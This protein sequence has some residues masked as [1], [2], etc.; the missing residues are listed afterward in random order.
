[1]NFVASV[2]VAA[3]AV[4]LF[5]ALFALLRDRKR[6]LNQIFFLLGC[7]FAVWALGVFALA[8]P[9]RR[10]DAD[11]WARVV[12]LDGALIPA[13]FLHLAVLLFGPA[14]PRL[15]RTSY[16]TA[17]LLVTVALAGGLDGGVRAIVDHHGGVRW[18]PAGSWGTAVLFLYSA[19]AVGGAL[20]L[21]V[22]AVRTSD[23]LRRAQAYYFAVGM[24]PMFLAAISDSS[25]VYL[26]AYPNF[27]ITTIP[28]GPPTAAFWSALVG[29]TILRYRLVNLDEALTLGVVRTLTSAV[30]AIPFFALILA[31]QK[32]FHGRIHL[33]FSV[34]ILAICTLAALIVPRLA[35]AAE[36]RIS[37]AILGQSRHYREA[38]VA[39]SGQA[40]RILD[41]DTLLERVCETLVSTLRVSAAAV[42]VADK[43]QGWRL[44][45]QRGCYPPRLPEALHERD[46]VVNWLLEH[47]QPAVREE[48]QLETDGGVLPVVAA[49]TQIGAE[50]AVP[51]HT[52]EALEGIV[53]LAAR[54][55]GAIFTQEDFAV[56]T[57]LGNQLATALANARLYADLKRSRELIQRNERLS[58]IGT[59]AAGLAHEIRN[60]LVSIRTFTQLLPERI[61]DREFRENFL[62][63]TL[64]EVDRICALI[65]EL[66]AFAR[67]APAELHRVS[68]NECLDRVCLLLDSQA[69]N[70]G[71]KL[72]RHLHPGR[73]ELTADEDQ[74]KQ[75]VINMILNA[76]QACS[77]RRGA[78]PGGTVTVRSYPNRLERGSYVSIEV[79]DDGV[80]IDPE[81]LE[82]IFDPFFTTR[83]EGTGLGL[84]IAHQI[85]TRHGGFIDVR[86]EPGRGASFCVNLPAEPYPMSSMVS[87]HASELSLHG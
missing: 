53:L 15:L 55:E 44:S 23:G 48:L 14:K 6:L 38:L 40:T 41:L 79:V 12:M 34:L 67:P 4:H 86:S 24:V 33:D 7:C 29:Y 69:R 18:Y 1:V 31:A 81:I 16:A 71:V 17:G 72:V 5:I 64:S 51:L 49:M 85:V 56:L 77:A 11:I 35:A 62:E 82:R 28:L 19:S 47:R 58:A 30:L 87:S 75:V 3:F 68:L 10:E 80:G 52:P 76:V 20:L 26:A 50:V 78:K 66:L 36:R 9:L 32:A 63:L 13:L 21:L 57:I 43:G 60:P 61:G 74:I 22:R 70:A 46:A 42:Y 65:N 59:M 83:K 73:L 2:A 84:S 25:G 37:Q 39:F 27:R 45:S 54:V 8:Q